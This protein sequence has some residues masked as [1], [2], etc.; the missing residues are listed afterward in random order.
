MEEARKEGIVLSYKVLFGHSS[1]SADFDL[2]ILK[3]YKSMG[4]LDIPTQ[5]DGTILGQCVDYGACSWDTLNARARP[6]ASILVT[7]IFPSA[8]I[9]HS[10]RVGSST[11]LLP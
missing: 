4:V 11:L 7:R 9:C 2:M 10:V 8:V 1:N 6:G 5:Q 3:E